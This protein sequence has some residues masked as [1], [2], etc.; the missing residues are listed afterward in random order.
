M[1]AT[2]NPRGEQTPAELVAELLGVVRSQ[3]YPDSLTSDK[4]SQKKWHQDTRLLKEFVIL[5][6]AGW[7]DERGLWLAPERYKGAL[8]SIFD[9]IKRHGDTGGV[10]SW[11]HY[12]GTCVQRRFAM[13][14]EEFLEE[15]KA[16]REIVQRV[17]VGLTK[18]GKVDDAR[19]GAALVKALAD[20]KSVLIQGRPRPKK[21]PA[22]LALP[23]F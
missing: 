17:T 14:A 13:R 21:V 4:G 7:L 9:E 23:G 22:T 1:K 20:A 2:P 16:A 11:P 5:W 15:G 10:K 19:R 6:P 12:L 3:F 8:L 18:H